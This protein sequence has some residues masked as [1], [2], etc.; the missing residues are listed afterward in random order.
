M[1][2]LPDKLSRFSP[3]Q[4]LEGS[5]AIRLDA[6]ESFISLPVELRDRIS[7]SLSRL[8][9][10]RYPDPYC[11]ELCAAFGGYYGVDPALV[12]AGNGSD[13]LIGL[14][15]ANL[16]ADGGRIAV[17]APDFSM[18]RFYAE[19]AQ[20]P[21]DVFDKSPQSLALDA[22]ALI[23]FCREYES[24]LLLLSNPC[25][26]TSL[27]ASR[28]D[29]LHIVR[30]LPDCLVVA[31]EAYMDFTDGSVL[32]CAGKY[33]NLL[34]L[35]TCSKAFG[36]AAIRLGFA[37]GS[38]DLVRALAAVKSPYNVNSMTQLVGTLLLKQGDYLRGCA[39][40]IKQSRDKLQAELERVFAGRGELLP[41]QAN[42]VFVKTAQSGRLYNE[43]LQHGV[44]LRLMGD[45][46]RITAGSEEE[47]IELVTLLGQLMDSIEE[48]LK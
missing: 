17:T 24:G 16:V 36:L 12:V 48:E 35:R 19:L 40:R 13:E 43:C 21:V 14:I 6:N 33:D 8:D 39:A 22:E 30:S 11:R 46:L 27:T 2:R 23:A 41:T 47:N 5:Y 10:N 7:D 20:V 25:N 9:F 28:N 37:V 42:F 26:P 18:Y 38:P 1:Y 29:M 32:D 31:D 3:Y 4:P 44:A 45:Y 15:V 34:V